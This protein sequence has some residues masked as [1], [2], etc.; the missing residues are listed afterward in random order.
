MKNSKKNGVERRC[1]STGSLMNTKSMIR[2]VIGPEGDVVPDVLYKL[3]GRGLWVGANK[4]SLEKAI[5]KNLFSFIS[6]KPVKIDQNLDQNVQRFVLNRLIKLI[7]LARKASQAVAG[8]EKAKSQ[9]ELKK[10][11][12]LIQAF[13]GSTR[14][15]SRLRPPNGENTLINCLNMQELGLAFSKESV[16]HA[17]ILN[18]GLYKE[19]SLE[20]LRLTGLREIKSCYST[21][22]EN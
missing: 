20:A 9:L 1:I 21:R 11:K 19:I 6:R 2:F 10:A 12:L 14:E 22:K 13:D 17:T 16:I 5:K 15:K 18:G 4:N 8:F 7:S 3:P